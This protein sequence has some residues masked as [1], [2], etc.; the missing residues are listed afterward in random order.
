MFR[1]TRVIFRLELY[2]FALSLCSEWYVLYFL[3]DPAKIQS[4][5]NTT[6]T[7]CCIYTV[8]LLMTGYR[9]VRNM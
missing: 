9:Y 3:V 7:N 5:K 2:L 6:G 1:L 8:Y 4:T